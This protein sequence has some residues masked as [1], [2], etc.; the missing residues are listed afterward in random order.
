MASKKNIRILQ[1]NL[2]RSRVAHDLAY[3]TATRIKADIILASEP[4]RA[5]VERGNWITDKNCDAA[6]NCINKRI[7]MIGIRRSKGWTRLEIGGIEIYS[8]YISANIQI[9]EYE[10]ILDE[11][12]Y[13]V[14]K[15][16]KEAIICGDLNAKSPHWGSPQSDKRGDM[17][18]DWI[19]SLNLNVC[20][21]GNPTFIRGK[22]QSHIDIS[23]VTNF[24]KKI[25]KW[26]VLDDDS[27]SHH[28]Y[29][30]FLINSEISNV[31]I[32]KRVTFLDPKKFKE[33]LTVTRNTSDN[34]PAAISKL[35]Q[36]A[37]Y[38][39]SSQKKGTTKLQPY[40]W[41]A[42]INEIWVRATTARR[43]VTRARARDTTDQQIEPI[44][45]Y[46]NGV[47]KELKKAI[48]KSKKSSWRELCNKLDDDIW[49]DGYRLVVKHVS[50]PTLPCCLERNIKIKI[51]R[52]LF[53]DSH[54][55]IPNEKAEGEA[56]PF[57]IQE[58][59]CAA[60]KIKTGR[61]PGLD[62]I[63]PEA[64]RIA[65]KTIPDR[66]LAMYNNL[67]TQG[68][69]PTEWKKAKVVLIPKTSGGITQ[70]LPTFRTICLLSCVGK[71]FETIIKE[72]LEQELNS[73][74]AISG[75]QFGFRRGKSTIQAVE[76][77]VQRVK[78]TRDKWCLFISVDVQ[79]AFNTASWNVIIR[80]LK[81]IGISPYLRNII[82]SYLSDRTI[83]V[84]DQI[85]EMTRGVPQGSVLGPTLWNVMYNGVLDLPLPEGCKPVAFAD[86][87][88]II[89]TSDNEI[90]LIETANNV[91]EMINDWMKKNH[92]TLAPQKTQ[93]IV[94][95]GPRKRDNIAIRLAGVEIRPSKSLKYL[96]IHLDVQMTFGTHIKQTVVK[97]DTTITKLSRLMPNIGGPNSAK[98]RVLCGVA[99]SVLLY[100]APIWSEMAERI[101]LYQNLLI[102]TQRK[103]LLRVASAYKSV[104]A[105]ALQVITRTVPI[106]L[107]AKERR[108]LHT[109]GQGHIPEHRRRVRKDIIVEWQG[110][111]D[112]LTTKAKWTKKLLPKIEPW[113]NCDH[114]NTNYFIT[115]FLSGHGSFQTYTHK[116]KKT[117]DEK[118]RYCLETDS[119]E[120]TFYGCHRWET[121]RNEA[122]LKLGQ[123]LTVDNTLDLMISDAQNFQIV[124]EYI[125]TIMRRKE[126]EERDT[127]RERN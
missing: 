70:D 59:E 13:E 49:G 79:N 104:S 63:L 99:Q 124:E 35:I 22:S 103:A 107:L 15:R 41:N 53:P 127:Q 42:E 2:G 51:V 21:D 77:V 83:T 6:I 65:V 85:L 11:L 125:R 88:G 36:S 119:P 64:L 67:I 100:G 101:K 33:Y 9:K 37:Q 52:D 32:D 50:T 31:N 75:Q 16:G 87:L 120:H 12:M 114:A 92:L 8:C 27:A 46:L 105:E 94:L 109:S 112:A 7:K 126:Q 118:C 86:D 14:Q 82:A 5:I 29:I 93:A 60:E 96:G 106:D 62:K 71:F 61:S 25:C 121:K 123:S 45:T 18:A 56:S 30:T 84:E 20:N 110:R 76:W 68:R 117:K 108:I 44:E 28:R 19:S 78:E 54:E 66:M 72:R 24:S 57:E 17:L 43:A 69:F 34:S 26:Q 10:H 111:W 122:Q 115:Q 73:K 90:P 40:W 95:K 1:I 47:R 98:R 3:A 58:L 38:R 23:L 39:A 48:K 91:L 97:V 113:I 81:K 102:K 80:N 4:N 74:E 89:V 55:S 116:I